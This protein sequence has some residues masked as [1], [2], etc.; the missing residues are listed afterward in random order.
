M[1]KQDPDVLRISKDSQKNLLSYLQGILTSHRNRSE[2]R[3]KMEAIDIKALGYDWKE[4]L[5]T[6]SWYT[7]FNE[8]H[9]VPF[10]STMDLL[11][12]RAGLYHPYWMKKK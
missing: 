3:E 1:A 7:F 10:L 9:P 11:R 6:R 5:A 12:M 2:I 4:L 8:K